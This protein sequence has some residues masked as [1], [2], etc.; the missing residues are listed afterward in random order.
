MAS[1][2]LKMEQICESG[3]LYICRSTTHFRE[4]ENYRS[5]PMSITILGVL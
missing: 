3:T 2:W 4:A 5:A 1:L